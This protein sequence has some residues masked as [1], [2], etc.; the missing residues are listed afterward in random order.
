[1]YLDFAGEPHLIVFGDAESGKTNL[2]RLIAHAVMRKY[3]PEDAHVVLVDYR[4]GLL[5]AVEGKH[6]LEY[7]A[8]SQRLSEVIGAVRAALSERLPGPD[9][10]PQQLRHRSWWKGPDLY[11]LIDDYDLVAGAGGNPVSELIDLL[12]Q[13]RDI[14]MHLVLAR[15]VGGAARS[16][17]EPV[18]QRLRELDTPGLLLSGNKEEG[19]LL[20]SVRPSL[21]PP[22][23][24]TLVRRVDGAQLVQTAWDEPPT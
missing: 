12:S 2:L 1:V 4:R 13:A 6:L 18:L 7:V 22:G 5:G 19:A 20:G 24:G 23:R 3:P 8:S 10:T 16:L 17:Y 21:L 11:I 14:G 15:R 9:V